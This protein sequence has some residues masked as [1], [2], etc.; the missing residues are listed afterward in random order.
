MSLR[1]IP[2]EN[3][4]PLYVAAVD[5]LGSP[6]AVKLYV[7]RGEKGP[8][9]VATHYPGLGTRP[10]MGFTNGLVKLASIIEVAQREGYAP[11]NYEPPRSARKN[12]IKDGA[13][14]R[15]AP[16]FRELSFEEQL[17]LREA[18]GLPRL[19]LAA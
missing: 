7:W 2:S 16:V 13:Q 8:H 9:H 17:A 18:Q 4:N 19:R 6:S 5:T 10:I 14:G 11:I 12:A 1:Y 15:Y 3:N